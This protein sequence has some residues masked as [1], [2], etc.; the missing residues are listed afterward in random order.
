MSS[1][2]CGPEGLLSA[3]KAFWLVLVSYLYCFAKMK[4]KKNGENMG[5]AGE[6]FM[7]VGCCLQQ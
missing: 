3:R 1:F 2:L 6:V 4:L 5:Q 7:N